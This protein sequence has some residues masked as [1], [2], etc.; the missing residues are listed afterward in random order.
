MQRLALGVVAALFGAALSSPIQLI[1]AAAPARY[2]P[3]RAYRDYLT[4]LGYQAVVRV[5]PGCQRPALVRKQNWFTG[6]VIGEPALV[7]PGRV[8]RVWV[9]THRLYFT[10]DGT[11][12]QR[13]VVQ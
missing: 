10:L 2:C 3:P 11:N 7:A 12:W 6:S 5:A 4:P 1:P 9:F 13:L 8:E